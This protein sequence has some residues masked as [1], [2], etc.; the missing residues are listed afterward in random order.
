MKFDV[1]IGNPPYQ[2]E[3]GGAGSS[4]IPLYN[5][6][7]E[8]SVELNPEYITMV[9]PSR[10]MKGGKGL[11]SFRESM[12]SD[13]RMKI[14]HD[15]SDAKRLFPTVN[16]DGGVNYFLW[17]SKYDGKVEYNY[18]DEDSDSI[19][20]SR[21]L[22]NG[23][24]PI[25]I[26]DNRQIEIVKKTNSKRKFDSIVSSRNP[27]G[28]S[29]DL[30][31]SPENYP[32]VSFSNENKKDCSLVYG[33]KGSK[34]GA[35]RIYKYVN[36]TSITKGKESV[37]K[38]KLLF[39]RA[40]TITA[41]TPP[42]IILGNPGELCTETFLKIGDFNTESEMLNCL[43]YIETKFFRAL[44]HYNRASFIMSKRVFSLIPLQDF[45]KSWT[46][47]ELYRKYKLTEAEIAYIEDNIEPMD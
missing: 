32:D 16:I 22:E 21:Y 5:K 28:F 3:D 31:N 29:S 20:S 12:M 42:E 13:K 35:K 40:Y 25:V 11:K 10:W 36:N 41:T 23:I 4:A 39:S 45:S 17:D 47:E 8:K 46:D 38:Y 1:I 24:I 34:G 43:S 26:R 18:Y 9:I 2:L 27:F 15:F 37:S 14:I 44:L 19:Y 7:I 6:F 30:F 33:V